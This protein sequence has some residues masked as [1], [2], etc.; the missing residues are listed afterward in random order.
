MMTES[1]TRR[2]PARAPRAAGA[3]ACLALALALAAPSA[4]AQ[5][6]GAPST[7]WNSDIE[8]KKSAPA[9]ALGK[10]NMTVIERSGS[11][12]KSGGAPDAPQLKLVALLTADGQQIDRGLVWRVFQSAPDAAGKSKMITENRDAS[13]SL[14]LQPGE[15][16]INASFGRANLTRKVSV[17]PNTPGTEKF[18]LNAGGLRLSANVAGK[19]AAP[20]MVSYVIFSDDRDQFANRTA[21]MTGAKPSLIIRLNAGIYRIVSTYGDANARVETDVTVEAGKLTEAAVAHA[22]GKANFKLVN[23]T[24]GEALPDT[25]WT[26]LSAEGETVKESVG[27]LPTHALA[28]GTYT[29]AAKS[30]GRMFKRAFVVKD[31][32]TTDVEVMSDQ[33]VNGPSDTAS[34]PGA[35]STE[36]AAIEP[37]L[38]IKSP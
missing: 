36:P 33:P 2:L 6:A 28:P 1:T 31:G 22:A 29:I 18:V 35:S 3:F 7:G 27:A 13:P 20:G 4:G 38:E 26:I 17:K 19:P 25:H 24:G 34:L 30:G 12:P 23:R 21:V 11:D 5:D 16:T 10:P 8:V 14:K 9:A 37:S 32:Q 15:Y